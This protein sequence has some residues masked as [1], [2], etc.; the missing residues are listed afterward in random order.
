MQHRFLVGD[1]QGMTG[2]MTALEPHYALRVISEPVNDLA[3]A[4]VSPLCTD[5]NNVLIHIQYRSI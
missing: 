2:I 4:L 3:L 1:D 5:N